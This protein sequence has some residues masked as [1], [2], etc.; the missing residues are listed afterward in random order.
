[1]VNFNCDNS[2][3]EKCL[4]IKNNLENLEVLIISFFEKSDLIKKHKISYL[5]KVGNLAQN[6]YKFLSDKK[7]TDHELVLFLKI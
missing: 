5:N 4:Q 2:F 3:D 1:M 7:M 6:V